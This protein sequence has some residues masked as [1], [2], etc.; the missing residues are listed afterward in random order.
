MTTLFL[1]DKYTMIIPI[2][3]AIP[4]T[5]SGA[6]SLIFIIIKKGKETRRKIT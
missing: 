5:S 4:G 6:P 3:I 1:E 2:F